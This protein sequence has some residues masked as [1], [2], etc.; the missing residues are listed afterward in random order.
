MPPTTSLVSSNSSPHHE[1]YLQGRGESALEITPDEMSLFPI[2]RDRHHN[3]KVWIA[4]AGRRAGG[5]RPEEDN[6]LRFET[7]NDNVCEALD[8]VE[9]YK[10]FE[11]SHDVAS[12]GG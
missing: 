12:K 4:L 3:E 7:L 9:A 5:V 11:F 1:N 6:Y 10:S 8:L 2:W